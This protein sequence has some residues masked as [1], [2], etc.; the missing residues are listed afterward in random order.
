MSNPYLFTSERLG[1]RNWADN[2]LA[3][4][5][6]INADPDVMR[7]F[8]APQTLERTRQFI[9]R[10]QQQYRERGYCYFA[11]EKLDT[12]ELIGFIGL[13]Y[14]D[15]PAPFTPCVDIGWRLGKA[16]WHQGLATEGA[17]RCLQYAFEDL[18]LPKIYA[19]APAINQP[20]IQVMQKIGMQFQY[21]FEHPALVGDDRLV[22]CVLYSISRADQ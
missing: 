3:T 10:M 21:N 15:Y 16:H 8:P 17:K 13:A 5:A 11:T 20:S 14:Q 9:D 6:S 1:F 12:A 19:I 7:Y 2:D 18:A 4:Q 22:N